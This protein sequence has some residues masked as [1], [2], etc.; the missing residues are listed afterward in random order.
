MAVPEQV[1]QL[2]SHGSQVIPLSYVPS[3]QVRTHFSSSPRSSKPE[4][5]LV[6]AS[7]ADAHVEQSSAQR[8][9]TSP[10]YVGTDV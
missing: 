10:S 9:Q 3:G 6:H 4:G 1:A 5:Q 8:V 7:G 2:E